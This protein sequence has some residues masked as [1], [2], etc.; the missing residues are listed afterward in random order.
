MQ[1][2]TVRATPAHLGWAP[3]T[4]EVGSCA[5]WSHQ[6][7]NSTMKRDAKGPHL[8]MNFTMDAM[9][10]VPRISPVSGP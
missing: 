8:P 6:A 9:A 10:P 2:S 1:S 5:A 3:S 4:L 7:R